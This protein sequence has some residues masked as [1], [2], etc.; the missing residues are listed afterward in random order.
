MRAAAETQP[1]CDLAKTPQNPR[2]HFEAL[3]LAPCPVWRGLCVSGAVVAADASAQG[4]ATCST[5]PESASVPV[6]DPINRVINSSGRSL[7]FRIDECD[8]QAIQ[9]SMRIIKALLGAG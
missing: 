3:A 4:T 9:I 7:H 2:K 6:S 8:Q 1:E 5:S